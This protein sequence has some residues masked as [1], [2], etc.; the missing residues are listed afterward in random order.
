MSVPRRSRAWLEGHG[1]TTDTCAVS[2]FERRIDA[3]FASEILSR[4]Y[5]RLLRTYRGDDYVHGLG[6]FAF[7]GE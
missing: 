7:S 2:A 5:G 3:H 6:T 4:S 1:G